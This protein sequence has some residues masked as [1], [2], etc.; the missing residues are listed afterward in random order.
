MEPLTAHLNNQDLW[1][2]PFQF[3]VKEG[4]YHSS[5][6]FMLFPEVWK[7]QQSIGFS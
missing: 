4:P 2:R 6:F 1:D 7:K 3:E 5:L